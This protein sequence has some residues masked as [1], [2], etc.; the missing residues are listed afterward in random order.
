MR[1]VLKLAAAPD[2]AT[3]NPP[4]L[5]S[6]WR[7]YRRFMGLPP[8]TMESVASALSRSVVASIKGPPP[9]VALIQKKMVSQFLVSYTA[10][11]AKIQAIARDLIDLA[12]SGRRIVASMT[13]Q[14]VIDGPKLSFTGTDEDT[15]RMELAR[16][17]T[18][19]EI[20]NFVRKCPECQKVFLRVRR[21]IYCSRPCTDKATWKKWLSRRR[22]KRPFSHGSERKQNAGYQRAARQGCQ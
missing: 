6:L 4:A 3:L 19:S 8:G 12:T 17:L 5:E 9:D 11:F 18:G 21:Q 16:L 1:Y 13:G 20:K 22:C 7:G 10:S 2:V 14:I 15:F